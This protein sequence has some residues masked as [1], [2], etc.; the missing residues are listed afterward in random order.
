MLGSADGIG[1]PW[2][3]AVSIKGAAIALGQQAHMV[4][5]LGKLAMLPY[6]EAGLPDDIV[7]HGLR[8]TAAPMIGGRPLAWTDEE[9]AAFEARWP[10]GGIQRRA[11]LLAKFTGQRCRKPG[12]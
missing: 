2:A 1:K 6:D 12:C 5:A 7:M 3:Q 10:A 9:C 4:A 11:Y 8:K